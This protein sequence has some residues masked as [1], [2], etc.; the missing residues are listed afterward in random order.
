MS[1]GDIAALLTAAGGGG[2]VTALIQAFTARG[3]RRDDAAG[4]FV[5]ALVDQLR[6]LEKR[7]GEMSHQ[8]ADLYRRERECEER[9]QLAMTEIGKLRGLLARWEAQHGAMPG[10]E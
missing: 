8:M 9:H 7:L 1:W 2:A 5:G 10:A 6:H 4:K 3:A